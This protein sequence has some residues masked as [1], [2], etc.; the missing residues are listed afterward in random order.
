M[1]GPYK[2]KKDGRLVCSIYNKLTKKILTTTYSRYIYQKHYNIIIEYGFEVH[3]KD[4]NFLNNS[5]D[6]LELIKKSDHIKMHFKGVSKYPLFKI[7]KCFQCGRDF[8]LTRKQLIRRT[9]A[10]RLRLNGPF[11]STSCSGLNAKTIQFEK[12]LNNLL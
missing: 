4:K 10:E 7:V 3:H 6:N 12:R 8:K 5:I 9:S 1:Y 11:C 2:S